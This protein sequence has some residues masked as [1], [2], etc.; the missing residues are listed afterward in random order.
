MDLSEFFK[1][2]ATNKFSASRLL[3]LLW[4][5]GVLV[6]WAITSLKTGVLAAIP[7]SVVTVLGNRFWRQDRSAIWGEVKASLLIS[8]YASTHRIPNAI[9]SRRMLDDFMWAD[10]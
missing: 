4:G 6:I 1:E 8:P 7:D 5:I 2:K 9:P 10:R 3:L